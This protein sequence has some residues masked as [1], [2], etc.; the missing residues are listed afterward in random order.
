M[1]ETKINK[2]NRSI[3]VYEDG[4]LIKTFL[5]KYKSR[6]VGT[7]YIDYYEGEKLVKKIPVDK[8]EP[9]LQETD[10]IKLIREFSYSPN[11]KEIEVISKNGDKIIHK[12]ATEKDWEII[13]GVFYRNIF[14]K[15]FSFMFLIIIIVCF[16]ATIKIALTKII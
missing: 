11:T 12:N 10:K 8:T 14:M 7:H 6:K 1:T 13:S 9:V 4:K 2:K 5:G 16:L 3:E 15:V